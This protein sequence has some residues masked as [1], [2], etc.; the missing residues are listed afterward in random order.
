VNSATGLQLHQFKWLGGDNLIGEI[1]HQWNHLVGF[2]R[3]RADA[4]LVHFTIGGPYFEE[5]RDCE[6]SAEW[7]AE[8]DRMLQAPVQRAKVAK[9]S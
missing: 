1:P 5:Y 3:P 2:D 7:F 8:R 4:S 9:A 6:Y